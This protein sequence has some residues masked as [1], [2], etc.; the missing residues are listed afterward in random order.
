MAWRCA[1][2][3]VSGTGP[4][5]PPLPGP[6]SPARNVA[7]K[8]TE[9]ASPHPPVLG[10]GR[11]SRA[12]SLGVPEVC[13]YLLGHWVTP[14]RGLE[15]WYSRPS[16]ASLRLRGI[17]PDLASRVS[18]RRGGRMSPLFLSGSHSGIFRQSRFFHV[19]CSLA[20]HTPPIYNLF[21]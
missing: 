13:H 12:P 8:G 2:S 21:P 20:H 17:L 1:S 7:P 14:L 19:F 6:G 9:P 18:T 16:P 11:G 3:K 10:R 5:P 4:A 15:P